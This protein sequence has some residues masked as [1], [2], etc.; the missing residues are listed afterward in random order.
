MGK[1]KKR[2][3]DCVAGCCFLAI[4]SSNHNIEVEYFIFIFSFRKSSFIIIIFPSRLVD[5][6]LYY[7][8]WSKLSLVKPYKNEGKIFFMSNAL[9]NATHL[10]GKM[11]AR[12]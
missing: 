2:K 12:F 1:K 3:R 7:L 8:L 6:D 11:G 10:K 9:P 5:I 4:I